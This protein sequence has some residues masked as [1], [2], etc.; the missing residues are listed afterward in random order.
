MKRDHD[1][2]PAAKVAQLD[3]VRAASCD[4]F[5]IKVRSFVANLQHAV[6]SRAF[7]A[8]QNNRSD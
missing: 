7:F 1:V 8:D 6:A 2:L 3:A 4:G 5:E